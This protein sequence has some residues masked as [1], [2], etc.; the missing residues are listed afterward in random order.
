MRFAPSAGWRS[1]R[2]WPYTQRI[3]A[4]AIIFACR[5]TSGCLNRRPGGLSML[6]SFPPGYFTGETTQR[7]I[8]GVLLSEVRHS[9]GKAVPIHEHEAP[10][11]SLLL[12]GAYRERGEGFDIR[13]EPYTLVFHSGR[14]VHEDEMLGACRFFAVNL[15]A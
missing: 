13:Y 6:R 2:R 10:Y 8:A 11:F 14:T 1:I 12:E 7:E 9:V 5:I 4:N 15:L 3:T